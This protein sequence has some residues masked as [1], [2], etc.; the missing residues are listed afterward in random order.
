MAAA[1]VIINGQ[2]NKLAEVLVHVLVVKKYINSFGKLGRE[3]LQLRAQKM[4]DKK[5]R[6]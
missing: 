6:V 4:D 1:P 5:S 2:E 3:G